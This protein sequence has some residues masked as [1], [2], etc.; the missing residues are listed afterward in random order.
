MKPEARGIYVLRSIAVIY[1]PR[2]HFDFGVLAATINV[3]MH[4]QKRLE[5]T[6]S[7]ISVSRATGEQGQDLTRPG[8]HAPTRVF[9]A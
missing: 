7:D 2:S 4:V 8:F 5:K 6:I 1:A 9:K 3:L